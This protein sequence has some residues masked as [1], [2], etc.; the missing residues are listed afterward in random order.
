MK[1]L[2]LVIVLCAAFLAGLVFDHVAQAAA[3]PRRPTAPYRT[4][5]VLWRALEEIQNNYVEE[6]EPQDLVFGAVDGMV[7]RLD[8]HSTFMRPELYRQMRED[9]GGEFDGVGLELTVEAGVL[10]VVSPLA[11][12][13]GERAG[14]KPGDR[15]LSVDG[16][17]T[18]EMNLAEAM[19]RLKGPAGTKVTLEVMRDTF[20]A[21]QKLTVIRDRIRVQ[22]VEWRV[23]D[24]DRRYLYARVKSFQDRT[25]RALARA[26]ED[27]RAALK[28][29]L[30]GLVLDLRNNPGGLVDEAVRVSDLFLQSGTIVVQEGRNHR[31]VEVQRAHEKGTE[32]G[33]LVIV[34]VNKGTASAAEIVAGALQDNGRAVI[35]G[36]QTFGKGSVQSI[37]ELP[38]GTALK[39]TTARYY[40]PRHRSIQ[41]VGITPD[42]VAAE[43]LPPARPD[44]QPGERD[45]KNHLKN[46]TSP[47]GAVAAVPAVAG[48]EADYPLK[49]A[50]D[51]LKAVDIFRA[52]LDARPS[53]HS[54]SKRD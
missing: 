17:A 7:A 40:T 34:L 33:Y 28:G 9:M 11:E 31:N 21:P 35:L 3:A 12:S 22:S 46:D 26:L 48:G 49:T 44:T 51:Y 4:T 19:R 2:V 43:V 5:E 45:L 13:P 36:T 38:D 23:L 52:T 25:E 53:P 54:T 27:G 16:A 39:L 15:L 30:R 42:V 32:P 8:P 50:L 47:G 41:E 29:E 6:V 24:P 20:A 10:T 14:L 18:R 1:R 37:I